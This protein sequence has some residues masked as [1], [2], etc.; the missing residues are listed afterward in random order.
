MKHPSLISKL[1]RT[2]YA[3]G[4][5]CLLP[6]T[7]ARLLC[8]MILPFVRCVF[9]ISILFSTHLL[10]SEDLIRLLEPDVALP[11]GLIIEHDMTFNVAESVA[12]AREYL[13]VRH[14]STSSS[15]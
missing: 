4:S 12:A 10:R 14:Q 5:V 15:I 6:K 8:S 1:C 11:T 7:E 13:A 9:F 2:N 3:T